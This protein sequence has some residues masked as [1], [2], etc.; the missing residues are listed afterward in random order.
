MNKV[1]LVGR[2]TTDPDVKLNGSQKQ[3]RF[4]VALYRD[5]TSTDMDIDYVSCVAYGHNAEFIGQHFKRGN[6]I[7]IVGTL[8][9]KKHETT[10]G[11]AVYS[12]RVLVQEVSYIRNNEDFE[13]YR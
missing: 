7:L 2:I 13:F 4:T 11:R 6:N 8:R 3:V 1:H 9:T 10:D 12:T 5:F